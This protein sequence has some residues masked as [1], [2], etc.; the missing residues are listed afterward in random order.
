MKHFVTLTLVRVKDPR[1]ENN[2]FGRQRLGPEDMETLNLDLRVD[3]VFSIAAA[4]ATMSPPLV[5]ALVGVRSVG[6]FMVAE[7]R[8]EVRALLSEVLDQQRGMDV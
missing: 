2:P 7:T 6:E 8:E 3:S 4:H 1:A 5:N